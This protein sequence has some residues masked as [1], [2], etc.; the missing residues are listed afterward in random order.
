MDYVEAQTEKQGIG[1][2]EKDNRS[3][4]MHL[5]GG[6]ELTTAENEMLEYIFS[7]GTY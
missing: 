2:F 6:S 7:S 3:L 1:V 4:A 5:F